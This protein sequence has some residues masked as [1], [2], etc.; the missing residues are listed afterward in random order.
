MNDSY[1][2]QLISEMRNISNAL[3]QIQ[4]QLRMIAAQIQAKT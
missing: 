4:E 2:A 1:A 3:R